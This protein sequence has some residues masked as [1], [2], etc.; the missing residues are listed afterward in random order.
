[1]KKILLGLLITLAGKSVFAE[2][3]GAFS[4]GSRGWN[5]LSSN[6][7]KVLAFPDPI[8]SGAT[9]FVSTVEATGLTF[10]SDPSDSSIA[11]RQ[12]GPISESDLSKI[13]KNPEGED[14]FSVD[15]GGFNKKFLNLF[16]E[17]NVRR[18]YDRKNNTL[19]YVTYTTKLIEGH[20]KNSLSA[21]TLYNNK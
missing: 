10:S 21:I 14:I 3:V 19:L 2:E 7:L 4:M 12:T 20:V 9:C 5:I 8:V 16:K 6:R 11:C 13:E 1:M 18:I 15:K 17:L